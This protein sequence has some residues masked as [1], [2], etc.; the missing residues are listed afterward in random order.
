M[1]PLQWIKCVALTVRLMCIV[2][3]W[4]NAEQRRGS[5][6][7]GHRHAGE[8]TG[9]MAD[10]STHLCLSLHSFPDFKHGSWSTG[11]Q[12]ADLAE[13]AITLFWLTNSIYCNRIEEPS[14]GGS[15]FKEMLHYLILSLN[16]MQMMI[17]FSNHEA[18]HGWNIAS[19][20]SRNAYRLIS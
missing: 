13:T 6:P 3:M 12:H 9:V 2:F 8:E 17:A 19:Q 20:Q 1:C 11:A 14:N 15:V 7:N 16:I 10:V 18:V 4:A 5:Q